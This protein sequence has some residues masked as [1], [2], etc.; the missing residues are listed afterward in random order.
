MN[1]NSEKLAVVLGRAVDALGSIVFLKML[2]IMLT[3]DNMGAYLLAS[4]L[5]AVLL[6]V[7][8]SASDQGLLRNLSD[9]R[10]RAELPARYSAM[11][12]GYLGIGA[13]LSLTLY[14][15][16]LIS[17]FFSAFQ[18]I[19]IPLLLWFISDALKNLNQ[20]VASGLR[21]RQLVAIASA[22]DYSCRISFLFW[23][24][25]GQSPDAPTVI[26]LLILSG[27]AASVVYLVAHRGILARFSW[28]KF[29]STLLEA[30][31]FSW[32]MI[33]WGFFAWLQNMSNRLVLSHFMDLKAVAEYGVL[34]S[35]A[36]FPVTALLGVIVTYM[37][38]VLYE[39]ENSRAGSSRGI[40][41]R[42]ALAMIPV[43][44][45]LVLSSMVWHRE[46]I[47]LLS[48]SEYI[49]RSEL[50]PIVVAVV[51]FNAVCSVLIY[52]V[53]AQRQVSSLLF[54]NVLPGV[55]CIVVGYHLIQFYG[56]EGAIWTLGLTQVL[57][58]V[59]FVLTY[60]FKKPLSGSA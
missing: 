12:V 51:S 59:L 37:V 31:A 16:S 5:L 24:G 56:F 30:L 3:K 20:T 45:V 6:T 41:V 53:L 34:V 15:I 10:D 39:H 25:M 52:S 19:W 40:V 7:T 36:S 23:L 33:I 49:S 46:I 13:V 44:V 28:L 58:G 4:S 35:I 48:S 43:C 54:A 11:L 57:G 14:G 1:F 22:V 21:S 9:Y 38:P 18:L 55:F 2:A 26:Y 8:F 17:G 32:P 50:L 47:L 42:T 29:R 60:L 27:V